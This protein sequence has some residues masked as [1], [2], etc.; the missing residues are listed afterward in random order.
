MMMQVHAQWQSDYYQDHPL[1][2]KIYATADNRWISEKELQEAIHHTR[3]LLLGETHTN[4]DHH[5]GQADIIHQWMP[6]D[7]KVALVMEM[8]TYEQWQP[9]T[10]THMRTE[11]LKKKL[12]ELAGVWKWHLYQPL[13]QLK[14]DHQLPMIGANLTREQ[15][16]Q[17]ASND[18]CKMSR[19]ETTLDFCELMNDSQQAVVKQLIY[20]AHCNYLP[21]E[22]TGSLMNTQIAKDA[23]FALSL[24]NVAATHKAVLIAGAIHV[25]KDIGVPVHLQQL[26]ETSISVA[27]INVDPEIIDPEQY[28]EQSE[29]D[30]SLN[31]QFDYVYFTPS[32]RNQ[33]PCVEFAEQLKKMKKSK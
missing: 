2:G 13:V 29:P 15:R 28:I 12:E 20:D 19:E 10:N 9:Y 3:I 16:S 17:Y 22:H 18:R 7:R 14:Q 26:G 6:A 31:S 33:D 5:S 23:S 1:V 21:Y 30:Q 27:F 4:P 11:E 24:G 8:L 32:E 25:R